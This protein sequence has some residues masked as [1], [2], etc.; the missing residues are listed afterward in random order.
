VVTIHICYILLNSEL[1]YAQR[2]VYVVLYCIA[3]KIGSTCI[4]SGIC[5]L[6]A[7]LSVETEEIIQQRIKQYCLFLIIIVE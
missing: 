4:L 6:L 5:Q 3:S 1:L 2:S 7:G